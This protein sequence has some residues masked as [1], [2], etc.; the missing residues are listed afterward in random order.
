MTSLSVLLFLN[1]TLLCHL[2][3]G[4]LQKYYGS[5]HPR[6][7]GIAFLLLAWPIA[8]PVIVIWALIAAILAR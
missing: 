2:Y 5:K 7:I 6:R 4:Q 3:I 8:L 1:G